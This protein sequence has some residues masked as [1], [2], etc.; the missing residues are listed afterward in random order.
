MNY[1]EKHS[2]EPK[3]E[4]DDEPEDMLPEKVY[5]AMSRGKVDYVKKVLDRF[6]VSDKR[7]ILNEWE[8]KTTLYSLSQIGV[9][10]TV[11]M[12]IQYGAN[13][14]VK[15]HEKATA[16]HAASWTGRV[17]VAELLIK[18][19]ANVNAGDWSNRTSLHKACRWHRENI[20]RLLVRN[21][22]DVNAKNKYNNTPLFE[23]ASKCNHRCVL[24]LLC[25]RVNIDCASILKDKT[26][27]LRPIQNQLH[28][29]RED[30]PLQAHMFTKEEMELI[31]NLALC[32]TIK[33]PSIAF[34]TFHILKS[35]ITF[36]GIFVI[37]DLERGVG[38][39]WNGGK[40]FVRIVRN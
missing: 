14:N 26:A 19:G 20:V 16:L 10:K 36:H 17:N 13:V 25:L 4:P 23:A 40:P 24:Q 33:I 5:V 27:L 3:D 1:L 30:K 34:K 2:Y 39:V 32:I 11:K 35:F 38:S 22:A 8:R 15:N 9:Y 31:Y 28:L 7:K 29:L 12:M 6:D 37:A 18:S 21:G